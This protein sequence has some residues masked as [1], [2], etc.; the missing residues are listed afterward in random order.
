MQALEELLPWVQASFSDIKTVFQHYWTPEH[1]SN[2]IQKWLEESIPFWMKN[3]RPSDNPYANTSD[4][5][6][7]VHIEPMPCTV[8]HQDIFALKAT[9]NQHWDA[10]FKDNMP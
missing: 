7:W 9:A 5:T 3:L 6:V 1:T 4:Y 10:M 8:H 2:M